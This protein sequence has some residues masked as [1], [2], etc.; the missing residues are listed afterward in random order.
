MSWC[1]RERNYRTELTTKYCTAKEV[2]DHPLKSITV[3]QKETKKLTTQSSVAKKTVKTNHDLKPTTTSW[4]GLDPLSM[5]LSMQSTVDDNPLETTGVGSVKENQTTS[6]FIGDD[7]ENWSSIKSSILNKYTT[8]ERLSIKTSFLMVSAT[9]S[10]I[11]SSTV[12]SAANTSVAD[13]VRHRLEQLD[14]FE[15]GSVKEMLNLT[16]TEYVN[17]IDELN[18]TLHESWNSDQRVKALKIVIQCSK[19]LADI[20][21]IQFYPSKY[22]LITDI[23]DNF[24]TLVYN[25]IYTKA[26]STVTAIESARETCRNWFYKIASVRELIPRFYVE[27]AILKVYGFLINKK[28]IDTEYERALKRLTKMIRGIGDPLVGVYARAYLCRITVQIAPQSKFIFQDNF[29]DFLLSLK[30][31]SPTFVEQTIQEQHIDHSVYYLLYSPAL[32]W[33]VYCLAYKAPTDLLIETIRQFEDNFIF[34]LD[35]NC[36][37]LI[38]NS[39]L[40]C[41]PAHLITTKAL[42]FLELIKRVN[43]DKT[44][45]STGSVANGVQSLSYYPKYNL[46]RNLGNALISKHNVLLELEDEEKLKILNEIWKLMNKLKQNNE[47]MACVE[48]W[49]EFVVKHFTLEEINTLLGEIIKRM[50]PNRAFEQHYSQLVGLMS[51]V[52][53]LSSNL[54]FGAL[55][56]MNNFM[57]FLDLLQ[58]ETVKVEAC[59]AIVES[60]IKNIN[61]C[62]DLFDESVVTTSDP[63]ILNSMT[64]LCKALHDSVSA[65]TLEDERRQI[66][67][68]VT[69]FLKHVSFSRD[70]EAE[71]NFYVD[72]R[73]NF[74]NLET[75]LCFLVQRVNTLAM[76]TRRIVKGFHTKKTT[77]FV[78]ACIAYSYITIPSLDDVILRLQLYLSSSHVSLIN[79]CLPQTDSFL[80]QAITLI[81]QLPQQIESSDGRPKST[82]PFL[83]SY[84]SQ[85]LSFLL[86]VP[87]NPDTPEPLYL[88][89]GLLNVINERQFDS[90]FDTKAYILMNFLNFLSTASQ[91]TYPYHIN[92]VDSNDTLYGNDSQFMDQIDVLCSSVLNDLLDYFKQLGDERQYKR[93]SS[94]ALELI[95]RIVSHS[96]VDEMYKLVI[97]LWQLSKKNCSPDTKRANIALNHLKHKSNQWSNQS[98]I[99][100]T[101]KLEKL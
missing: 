98:L 66:S 69:S 100:L 1:P 94:L 46:I 29:N 15:E 18:V 30:Q 86:L 22:V 45:S 14:D 61:N 41:F 16:Q 36:S 68:L 44:A 82:E 80:K 55:F 2:T 4:N 3:S 97:N 49:I 63:V 58:K 17:R 51:K 59:K 71:L 60:F 28:D 12:R 19:L 90:N 11:S 79:G 62:S 65:L 38:L 42:D 88:F 95:C 35:D 54:D 8:S 57:P 21:V 40:T 93:Q 87:D 83:L 73:A 24:G 101:A 84:V 10:T 67:S 34:S 50:Q 52:V 7:F 23:L 91:E 85:L 53:T 37:A 76:E 92:K 64:Y 77:S 89:K 70:F 33:I 48:V 99:E 26:G 72:S 43:R 32:D 9:G 78:R 20:S 96:R 81:Q 56:S 75:V 5:A 27:T 74:C 25:R 31:L 13:K 6:D 39:L 47:Y